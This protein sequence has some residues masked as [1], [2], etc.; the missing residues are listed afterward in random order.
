M[1][2]TTCSWR[3]KL[4]LRLA[5]LVGVGLAMTQALANE[6]HDLLMRASEEQRREALADAVRSI[7]RPCTVG[8]ETFFQGFGT[9]NEAFWNVR[10]SEGNAYSVALYADAAASFSVIECGVLAVRTG[11]ECWQLLDD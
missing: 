10:C 6:A 7:G 1:S 5:A 11:V 3:R 9:Y 8:T 4:A 2:S